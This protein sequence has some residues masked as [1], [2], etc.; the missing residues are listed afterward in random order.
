MEALDIQT[1][2]LDQQLKNEKQKVIHKKVLFLCY[3]FTYSL[4]LHFTNLHACVT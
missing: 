1:P 2:W 3:F 4:V